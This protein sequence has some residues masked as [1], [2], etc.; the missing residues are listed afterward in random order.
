[1]KNVLKMFLFAFMI[2]GCVCDEEPSCFQSCLDDGNSNDECLMACYG[3]PDIIEKDAST[4]DFA[5]DGGFYD[6]GVE[7]GSYGP[8]ECQRACYPRCETDRRCLTACLA[9]C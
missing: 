3:G 2:S 9:A 6:G 4:P 1:M 5:T 8:N 7:D